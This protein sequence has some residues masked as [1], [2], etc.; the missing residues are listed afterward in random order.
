M[1]DAVSPSPDLHLV[2]RNAQ[3]VLITEVAR[4]GR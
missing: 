3:S 1:F 4:G 2:E